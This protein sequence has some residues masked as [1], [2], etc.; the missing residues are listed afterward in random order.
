MPSLRGCFQPGGFRV[1]WDTQSA[2]SK[3]GRKVACALLNELEGV[4]ESRGSELIVLVQHGNWEGFADSTAVESVLSCISDPSTRVFDLKP[5]LSELK[6]KD[7]PRH[8][9][10]YRPSGGHMTAEGNQFVAREISPILTER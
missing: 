1:S 2:K 4:A 7:P 5:A 8:N 6:A 9:R 3:K 10:L